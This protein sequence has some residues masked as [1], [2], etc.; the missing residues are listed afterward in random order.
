[1]QA[2]I[3]F[4]SRMFLVFF[5][6]TKPASTS[7]K[8]AC[9]TSNVLM[10]MPAERYGQDA[11]VLPQ[12]ASRRSEPRLHEERKDADDEEVERIHLSN[13]AR[14]RIDRVLRAL[15]EGRPHALDASDSPRFGAWI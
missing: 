13:R 8:P 6:R 11:F 3:K 14:C 4:F 9:G 1:M 7:A 10:E 5:E 15:R 12:S 2:S